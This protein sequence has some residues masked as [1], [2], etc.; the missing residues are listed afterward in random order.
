MV[1]SGVRVGTPAMTTRGMGLEEMDVLGRMFGDA[2]QKRN[3]AGGLASLRSEVRELCAAF[4]LP[5]RS[6]G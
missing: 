5:Y 3:D 6:L 4:P 1:A 2:L